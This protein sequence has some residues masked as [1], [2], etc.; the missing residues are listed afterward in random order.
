MLKSLRALYS[1]LVEATS[2]H[3]NIHPLYT[4]LGPL[5]S[6]ASPWHGSWQLRTWLLKLTWTS[7][8]R[9]SSSRVGREYLVSNTP[10]FPQYALY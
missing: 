4:Q 2:E 3:V 8:P 6:P 9:L 7:L 1:C 5:Q 10:V